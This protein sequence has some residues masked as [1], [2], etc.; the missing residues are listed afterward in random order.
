[1]KDQSE[2]DFP[3]TS[4]QWDI[5]VHVPVKN[6]LDTLAVLTRVLGEHGLMLDYEAIALAGAIFYVPSGWARVNGSW[7]HWSR[8]TDS[9][10]WI[11]VSLLRDS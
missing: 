6:K 4:G 9:E 2:L 11:W 10:D 7:V 8:R 5:P 3:P 1:L